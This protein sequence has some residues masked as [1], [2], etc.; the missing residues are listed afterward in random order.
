LAIIDVDHS[1][2]GNPVLID[3]PRTEHKLTARVHELPWFPAEKNTN[4]D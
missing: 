4:L 2:P 1:E 3:S